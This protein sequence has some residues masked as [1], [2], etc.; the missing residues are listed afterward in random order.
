VTDTFDT[1]SGDDVLQEDESSDTVPVTI[2]E[3]V[4]VDEMPCDLGM[5]SN[6]LLPSGGTPRQVLPYDPRRKRVILWVYYAGS[7]PADTLIGAMLGS[8]QAEISSGFTGPVLWSM[9][10]ITKYEFSFRNGL[11]AK[12]VNVENTAGALDGIVAST[13]DVLLNVVTEEWAR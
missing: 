11:W 10:A 12:G 3:V 13:N 2:A 9:N 8:S 5:V 7:A 6:I 4:R 1:P